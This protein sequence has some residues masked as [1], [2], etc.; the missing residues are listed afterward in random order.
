MYIM[1]HSN[2]KY[3]VNEKEKQSMKVRFKI[4]GLKTHLHTY[5]RIFQPKNF[6]LIAKN[7]DKKKP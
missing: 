6:F 7:G 4:L 2:D 5:A 1:K 3:F